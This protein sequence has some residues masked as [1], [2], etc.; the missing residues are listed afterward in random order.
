MTRNVVE[1]C[2]RVKAAVAKATPGG[3]VKHRGAP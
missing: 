1:D 2:S 3:S